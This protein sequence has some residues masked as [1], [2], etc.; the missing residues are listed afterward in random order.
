M[1]D[2]SRSCGPHTALSDNEAARI[3]QCPCGTVHVLLRTAGVTVQLPVDRFQQVGLAV[4]GAVSA[5]GSRPIGVVPS[6][7]GAI[8]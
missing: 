1:A 7:P 3:T 8:N 6:T 2:A 5:L 4:M